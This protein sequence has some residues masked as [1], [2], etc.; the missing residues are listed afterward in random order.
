MVKNG[1]HKS[2]GGMA[3]AAIIRRGNMSNVF[4]SSDN[5]IVARRA[6]HGIDNRRI[7]IKDTA[8]KATWGVTN[9]AI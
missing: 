9:T 2:V 7:M 6:G 5:V 3:I 4:T 1:T 8:G